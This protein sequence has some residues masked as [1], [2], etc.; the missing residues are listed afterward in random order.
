VRESG[1]KVPEDIAF[2]TFD[3]TPWAALIEPPL[4]VIEQPTFEIGRTALELL[5]KRIE[6]PTRPTREVILKSKLAIRQSCGCRV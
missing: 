5:A 6:N 1:L 2:A 4:T 3:E